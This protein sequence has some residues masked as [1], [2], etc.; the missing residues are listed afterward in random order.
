MSVTRNPCRYCVAAFRDKRTGHHRPNFTVECQLCGNRKEYNR[1]LES[2]RMFEPGDP[3]TELS[4]LL[5]Q[6]WVIWHGRTRHIEMFRSMSVR[7][8]EEFLKH[9]T[10]RKAIRKE[11][12]DG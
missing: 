1:H 8:V 12:N 4:E 7:T 10:F 3:I 2:K 6:E 11:N 9:G 5:K